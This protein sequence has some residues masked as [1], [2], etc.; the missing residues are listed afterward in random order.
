MS[1]TITL[2]GI[3]VELTSVV[4]H[5]F[6]VSACH[7]AEGLID[8]SELAESYELTPEDLQNLAN[9]K[10]LGRAIKAELLR[11]VNSGTAARQAAAKIFVRAPR[12]MG[13]ILDS[14]QTPPRVKIEAAKEIRQTAIGTGDDNRSENERISIRIDLTASGGGVIHYTADDVTPDA[15]PKLPERP[16]LTVLSNEGFDE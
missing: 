3:E 10:A 5:E 1:D 9:N 16:K 7:A 13:E 14:S 11:R 2:R 4:A 15:Q 12:V 6:V 8:D